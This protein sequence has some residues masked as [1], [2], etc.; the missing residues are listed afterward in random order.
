MC[1]FLLEYFSACRQ[2]LENQVGYHSIQQWWRKALIEQN[3][4]STSPL[5][6]SRLL[7]FAKILSKF[8]IFVGWQGCLW[9]R[10]V[11]QGPAGP[12]SNTLGCLHRPTTSTLHGRSTTSQLRKQAVTLWPLAA[13]RNAINIVMQLVYTFKSIYDSLP[14]ALSNSLKIFP[15][16]N[17]QLASQHGGH[18]WSYTQW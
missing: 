2:A 5:S 13:T 15:K 1:P 14:S 8:A 6:W 18:V 12:H 16:G 4:D 11:L 9:L 3:T 10:S 17:T 7:K